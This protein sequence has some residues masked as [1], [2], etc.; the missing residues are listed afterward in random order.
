MENN[1]EQQPT[2]PAAAPA[3]PVTPAAAPVEAKKSNKGLI[4]GICSVLGVA[5]IGTV[6]AIIVINANKPKPEDQ[7]NDLVNSLFGDITD[8]TNDNNDEDDTDWTSWLTDD[9]E[10]EED[11]DEYENE[12]E[13]EDDTPAVT[14]GSCSDA[15][16]CVS[17]INDLMTVE[18]INAMTGI[19]GE[20]SEYSDTRYTWE[21]PNGETL[22][23]STSYFDVS[24]DYKKELHKDSSL[25]LSGYNDIK[26]QIKSGITYDE[27]VSAMK[28]AKGVV[29]KKSEYSTGYLWVDGK[30]G[31][32]TASVSD[33]GK[34]TS[35][36]GMLY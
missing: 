26:D 28:G 12:E 2:A 7:L 6:I 29:Y 36:F 30:G 27:F 17:K 8:N 33:S 15:F 13:D 21:F 31:Y 3:E 32:L 4:I 14:T 11:G 5:I 25:D 35:V 34:I 18:Q 10:G 24:V 9:D 16:E 23:A 1:P 20:K 19:E 22:E